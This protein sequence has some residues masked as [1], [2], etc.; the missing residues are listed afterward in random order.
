VWLLLVLCTVS[1]GVA[2]Y[3][4]H[5]IGI[6]L[7][8]LFVLPICLAA[9]RLNFKAG[10]TVATIASILSVATDIELPRSLAQG[11]VGNLAVH[12]LSFTAIAAIV[13]SFRTSY[14]QE[15]IFARRDG[16]SG[17]LTRQAFEQ[18]AQAMA[19]VAAAHRW[20]LLLAYLDLDGFKGVNDRHGHEAGDLVL[21][22]FGMEGR[23]A[24]RREDCFGRLGGDEFAL[25]MLLPSI[26]EAQETADKL[27]KRFTAA[28]A[29]T[30]H[31]VTCSMGA[32]AIE[33]YL[34]E[35][36]LD[37]LMRKADRL[38]YAAKHGGKDGLRFGT[39]ASIKDNDSLL[40]PEDGK[41]TP[42]RSRPS[43]DAAE[44][45]GGV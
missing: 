1:L 22:H 21:K 9:W 17:A 12:I 8:P 45:A 24:I 20:P 42:V 28:L 27:H 30:N 33:P 43:R 36:Y 35:F 2:N 7:S 34:G 32:L 38:M 15:R 10:L 18:K 19:Q 14:E 26:V 23:A 13:S 39:L 41:T 25:L 37:E 6:Q 4:F 11:S 31:P 16:V 29:N 3:L 5:P 40:P 44:F